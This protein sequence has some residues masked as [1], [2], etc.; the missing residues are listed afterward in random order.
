MVNG[1]KCAC[2]A[3]LLFLLAAPLLYAQSVDASVQPWYDKVVRLKNG[4]V[5]RDVEVTHEIEG[6]KYERYIIK[7]RDGAIVTK[8]P[9]EILVIET[10]SRTLFPP[11]YHP[12]DI[13]FPCDDRQRELQ[14]YFA[15][16][17][18]W[19]MFTGEDQSDNTIG[20]EQFTFGPELAAGWR[21]HPFGI[22]LGV[23]YFSA[24]QIARIPVFLHARW[25]LSA[26]CFAPFLYALLGTVFDDQSD[27]GFELKNTFS[28]TP[29]ILGA[30]I[31]IDYPVAPW[32]DLSIDLGYRYLQ[33]PTKVPCDCSDQ[34]PV[35]E[36]VYFNESHGVL[37]RVGATF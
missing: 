2:S 1:M 26:R 10:H 3:I 23:S 34:H 7:T 20:L 12:V 28:P 6:G 14:W 11:R 37:L 35:F 27:T 5:L 17:R 9:S 21:V 32:L 24:R 33:L 8:L 25:Q 19:G 16:L 18:G 31:G 29:K 36:A 30:G 4:S 15:E 13:V 22:G